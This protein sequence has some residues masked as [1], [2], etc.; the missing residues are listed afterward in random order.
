MEDGANACKGQGGCAVPLQHG[1]KSTRERFEA[2]MKKAGK[3]FG[4]APDA[5]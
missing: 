5:T 3:E 1:W 4:P 2:A